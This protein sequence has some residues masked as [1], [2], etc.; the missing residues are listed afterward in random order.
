MFDEVVFDL[1]G[2]VFVTEM[3]DAERSAFL[4]MLAY[5]SDS[6][7]F[8]LY[9]VNQKEVDIN[10][11]FYRKELPMFIDKLEVYDGTN[12]NPASL[13][14]SQNKERLISHSLAGGSILPFSPKSM[15][16]MHYINN[17]LEFIRCKSIA[18]TQEQ[19]ESTEPPAQ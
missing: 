14:I 11:D 6:M 7:R 8:L 4:A 2:T 1:S 16:H 3:T 19:T 12:L 5:Y 9:P 17:I 18:E 13:L 15:S 10:I